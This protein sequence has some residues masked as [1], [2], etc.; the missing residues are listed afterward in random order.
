MISVSPIALVLPKALSLAAIIHQW[1]KSCL[2]HLVWLSCIW[3]QTAAQDLQRQCCGWKK[4]SLWHLQIFRCL[5][6]P[7]YCS[8]LRN[9]R[10]D[11]AFPELQAHC[12]FEKPPFMATPF[13]P[14]LL[15]TIYLQYWYMVY[16]LDYFCELS[17]WE[18]NDSSLQLDTLVYKILKWQ[19][20]LSET[21][22]V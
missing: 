22:R 9:L 14:V 6:R 13:L 3:P 7:E 4:M 5:R 11:S 20:K 2:P 19:I 8:W 15:K 12:C 16:L 18:C 21:G 1:Y 17:W 10:P